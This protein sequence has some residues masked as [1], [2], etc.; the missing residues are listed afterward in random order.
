MSRLSSAALPQVR[1]A[2]TPAYD[3]EATEIGVVHFGPGAFHRAHQAFYFDELL[4]RDPRWA[5]SAVSL[6]SP[7]VRDA[8]DPQ[9]GLYTLVELEAET[10]LR[11]IGAIREV[12]VAPEQPD[13]VLARLA[14][15]AVRVV[16]L[17]I[18]EKGYC[19][20]GAGALDAAHPDVF[21]D[22]T[23][24]DEAPKSAIGWLVAGLALRR[25]AELP[26]L[27]VLSCDNLADNGV[28]LRGAV[29]AF[30]GALDAG[31]A[32]WI[33][34]E[35]RFPRTMVDSITPA[36]DDALRARVLDAAGVEDAWPIQREAFVQWVVEDVMRADA[37]DLAC[38]GVSLTDDVGG[39]ERAKLRLLNGPHSTLAYA[40]LLRGHTTVA[41]AMGDPALAGF[42]RAMMLEDIAPTLTP[43]AGLDL[44]AYSEAVLKRFRNPAIRHLLSQIAWDGSQKLP[45]RILGTVADAL[46][47]GRSVER[48]VV[49]LAAWMRF[50]EMRTRDG[51]RIVDP[52][53]DRLAEIATAGGGVERFLALASVFPPALA[54]D[55]RFRG[56]LE[57]A[58]ARM[59]DDPATALSAA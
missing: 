37:P 13:A 1:G 17:T 46:G 45:F 32:A 50:V 14:S 27:T 2:A 29:L 43:P 15:P 34:A 28:R 49:P 7:G 41:E 51:E 55:P 12:L 59:G 56:P 10:K 58:Y 20:D 16:T 54:A 5:I 8:L 30:A 39:W 52:L 24:P 18:T 38:V 4:A 36:T 42:V 22:L 35:C 6:K 40:G 23:A 47:A 26:G 21:H 33:E 31:L 11:V 53:G 9:D 19:L 57:A 3:R 25:A 48:L 44:A